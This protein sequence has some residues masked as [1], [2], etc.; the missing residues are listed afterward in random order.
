MMGH[1]E[2]AALVATDRASRDAQEGVRT[3]MRS[4]RLGNLGNAIK[5]TSDR[6]KRRIH[7]K[8]EMGFSASGIVYVGTKNERTRGALASY[9][10][11]PVNIT[12]KSGRKWLAIATNEIPKRVGRYRMTPERYRAS[13][14]ESRI[15]ELQFIPTSR[16][17]VA[18]LV[19]K[20]VTTNPLRSGSARRL[21]KNGRAR[22]GRAEVGIVAFVLIRATRRE[23]RVDVAEIARKFQQRII[24]YMSEELRT[25]R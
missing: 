17:N 21:P 16:A 5:Q 10:D 23:K 11:G 20:H 3:S 25:R 18:Y 4:Q 15:G 12:P 24:P 7:R 8:G 1:L 2:R 19:A 13:G 22:A 6:K 14:L 9:L